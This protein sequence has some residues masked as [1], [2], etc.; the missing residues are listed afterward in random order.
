[1]LADV[2]EVGAEHVAHLAERAL[3]GA[4]LAMPHDARDALRRVEVSDLADPQHRALWAALQ[5]LAGRGLDPDPALV[6]PELLALGLLTRDRAGLVNVQVADLLG[7]CPVPAIWPAYAAAVLREAARR[8]VVEAA[9]RAVQAADGPDLAT[10]VRVLADGLAAAER[11]V[12][13]AV[14]GDQ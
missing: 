8:V 10:V 14:G 6:V 13:R 3:L 2:A 5:S 12:A 1:M 7:A 4:V 11:A 9:T